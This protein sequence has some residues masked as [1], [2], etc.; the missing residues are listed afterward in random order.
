MAIPPPIAAIALSLLTFQGVKLAPLMKN[1]PTVEMNASAANLMTVV[2]AWTE[3]MFFTPDRLIT[4]GIHSPA[5]TS[6]TE[7]NLFWLLLMKCST[8]STQPTAIAALPAHAVIQYDHAFANPSPLPNATRAYAY[9]PP[10]AGN[11]RDNAANSIA[12]ASAP[13]VVSA[14]EISVIGPY[15]AREVGRLKMPT[16]MMLPMIRAIAWGRPNFGPAA[17][18]VFCSDPVTSTLSDMLTPGRLRWRGVRPLAS[19]CLVQTFAI[20]SRP[21]VKCRHPSGGDSGRRCAADVVRAG[22][23]PPRARWLA[24]GTP[25]RASGRSS[26]S[27]FSPCSA[28]RRGCSPSAG[29]CWSAAAAGCAARR[30]S[31]AP[32]AGCRAGVRPAPWRVHRAPRRSVAGQTDPVAVASSARSGSRS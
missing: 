4:A 22:A 13:T 8:Y 14:I 3:P 24:P 15:D 1:R 5:S 12:S 6:S 25:R 32:R 28:R 23:V 19:R 11:R 10:S 27:G 2:T 7:K 21:P 20:V 18:V 30:G 17:P 16:P 26:A 31:A 29:T 9:G